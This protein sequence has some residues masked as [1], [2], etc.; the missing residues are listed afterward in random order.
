MTKSEFYLRLAA[1]L[2]LFA[3]I[4]LVVF[5][6]SAILGVCALL[7]ALPFKLLPLDTYKVVPAKAR[8]CPHSGLSDTCEECARAHSV[9]P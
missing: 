5:V 9:Y 3:P 4:Y 8:E 6:C 7:V 2:I 1:F